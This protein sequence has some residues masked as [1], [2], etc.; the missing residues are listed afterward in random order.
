[1]DHE[2][3]H[4]PDAHTGMPQQPEQAPASNDTVSASTE[5]V[6]PSPMQ[7]ML[8]TLSEGQDVVANAATDIA[9][10]RETT[11]ARGP[12]GRF[13]PRDSA[14]EATPPMME[15]ALSNTASAAEPAVEAET[16]ALLEGVTSERSRARIREIFAQ[17]QQAEHDLNEVREMVSA[18]GMSPQDFAQ[19]LE[20]GRLLNTPDPA[21]LQTALQMVE[22]Q[23]ATLCQRL[24]I[25]RPGVDALADAPDLAQ[26]VQ[27]GTLS[28][29]RALEV[30]RLRRDHQATQQ[31]LA[32]T[33]TQQQAQQQFEQTLAQGQQE[34]AHYLNQRAQ[35][36]DHPIRMQAIQEYFAQPA[37][38]QQFVSTYAPQQWRHAVQWMYE[39]IRVA[40][41]PKATVQPLRAA[42]TSLGTPQS[43]PQAS[44]MER[45]MQHMDSMGL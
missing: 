33:T 25:E 1:M 28:R 10:A 21:N 35:E 30:A 17:R 13:I 23:R 3:D 12:D 36:A 31:R 15:E 45:L 38:V 44:T 9:A 32:E 43:N 42:H 8:D 26:E 27:N 29:E 18:T 39:Q 22:A 40:P 2:T 6:E 37:N 5:P 34:I 14:A 19:T 4:T 7:A 11:P 20:F 16:E 41:Q 24:G